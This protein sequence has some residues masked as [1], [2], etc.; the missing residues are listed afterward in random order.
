MF[1]SYTGM[2]R[3]GIYT[4]DFPVTSICSLMVVPTVPTRFSRNISEPRLANKDTDTGRSSYIPSGM[5]TWQ[6]PDTPAMESKLKALTRK[7]SNAV[8][9]VCSLG[10]GLGTVGIARI[11]KSCNKI[12]VN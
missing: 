4:F 12:Y 8:G 11:P 3:R 2:N 6:N 5:F 1:R 9:S 7:L 10:G